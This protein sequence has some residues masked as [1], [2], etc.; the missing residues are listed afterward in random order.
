MSGA[1]SN[2]S[3][4]LVSTCL[5][6][7]VAFAALAHEGGHDVRG[8]VTAVTKDELTVATKKGAEHFALTP[9]TEFVKDG[10]PASAQ[11]LRQSDRVVVHSKPNGDRLEAIKVEFARPKKR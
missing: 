11:D 5:A 9:Q 4:A 7:T 8:V 3:L 2:A 6:A 10:S 1:I